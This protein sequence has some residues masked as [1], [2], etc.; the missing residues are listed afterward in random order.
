MDKRKR[1]RSPQDG[2]LRKSSRSSSNGPA[3]ARSIPE[4]FEHTARLVSGILAASV[5][6]HEHD[7]ATKRAA[8]AQSEYDHMRPKFG[9]YP[10]IAEAKRNGRNS[11]IKE[12]AKTQTH[13]EKLESTLVKEFNLVLDSITKPSTSP[14]EE[15]HQLLLHKHEKVVT[16]LKE[17]NSICKSLE[18]RVDRL[19][20]LLDCQANFQQSA[21]ERFTLVEQNVKSVKEESASEIQQLK[22]HMDNQI[23][24]I[25]NRIAHVDDTTKDAAKILS[26]GQLSMQELANRLVATEAERSATKFAHILDSAVMQLENDVK[27]AVGEIRT[28]KADLE[29]TKAVKTDMDTMKATVKNLDTRSRDVTESTSILQS[30]IQPRT[31]RHTQAVSSIYEQEQEQRLEELQ[32]RLDSELKRLDADGISKD[33]IFANELG[34]LEGM[35]ETEVK[36]VKESVYEITG[37]IEKRMEEKMEACREAIAELRKEATL[38]APS[39]LSPIGFN[40]NGT[41]SLDR[42]TRELE[43]YQTM[44]K[45]HAVAINDI[46]QRISNIQTDALAQMILDQIKTQDPESVKSRNAVNESRKA[47]NDSRTAIA[48]LKRDFATIQSDIQVGITTRSSQVMKIEAKADRVVKSVNDIENKMSRFYERLTDLEKTT[49]ATDA[50]LVAR[51]RALNKVIG[52]VQMNIE[53]ICGQAGIQPPDW[54]V[55]SQPE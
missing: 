27:A 37:I 24:H 51:Y 1:S 44:T 21:L 43:S 39:A 13:L 34:L 8:I 5:A 42:M 12:V 16:E 36:N 30:A 49:A 47:I 41:H 22:N 52:V 9:T 28:I 45:V 2:P 19:T 50:R 18:K 20:G 31:E 35:V 17:T 23:A 7:V 11:T 55:L 10:S 14:S 26:D 53:N 4:S 40:G 29:A 48:D 33:E 38:S 25:E 3:Q 54:D 32:K 46:E 15:E 6:K